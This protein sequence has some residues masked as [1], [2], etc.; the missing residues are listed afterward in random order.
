MA[1]NERNWLVEP[2]S[3]RINIEIGSDAKLSPELRDA[4]QNL[5]QALGAEDEVQGFVMKSGQWTCSEVHM[6]DCAILVSCSS[7]TLGS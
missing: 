3:A 2:R 5:A 6:S 4:L 7:V 1:E